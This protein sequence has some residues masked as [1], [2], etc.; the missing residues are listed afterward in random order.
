MPDNPYQSPQAKPEKKVLP[1][2]GEGSTLDR[3]S[4]P[5]LLSDSSFWGLTVTQFLGAFNDNLVKQTLLLLFVAIPATDPEGGTSDLQGLGAPIFSLPFILFSGLAGY[6]SDKFSKR[7]LIVICKLAEIAIT[8]LGVLVFAL[9]IGRGMSMALVGPFCIILF[10]MGTHSAFFGPG[11]Y[12]IL[13]E[14]LRDRD[15]EAANGLVL[16][17]TF[18][19]LIL[20]SALAGPLLE[21]LGADRLWISGVVGVGIA[22]LGTGTALFIRRVPPAHPGLPFRP[23]SLGVP[24]DVA[25]LMWRDKPLLAAVMA[26]SMFWACAAMVQLAVNALG[27]TQLEASPAATS[28]MVSCI[29]IG[30]AAGSL[31]ASL[32]SRG[33]FNTR[34]LWTG[35]WG[36]IVCL[37]L[38]AIPGPEAKHSHLLGYWGSLVTLIALGAF[39]GMFA[40]PL[41]TFVQS[42]APADC[43]G[44]VVATQNL[45][46]WI[47][48]TSFGLLYGVFPPL[49][50]RLH[51]PS[52]ITFA[53]VAL[54]MLSIAVLYR[55]RDDSAPNS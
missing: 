18:L 37:A 26:S 27:I 13:P 34:I 44:R 22:V 45:C 31:T 19:A 32:S 21:A 46:Q 2:T 47:G 9:L 33:R 36:M 17:T 54:C 39:T 12:G 48:I 3:E 1:Q 14:M 51:W 16:M 11:K 25:R 52:C 6:L 35:L 10:L 43:K 41:Q 23:S 7:R 5:R 49:L 40:V 15:L 55:P 30:I 4:L 20:G 50:K 8:A 28:F 29:S 42:R 53:F 24:G 38:L